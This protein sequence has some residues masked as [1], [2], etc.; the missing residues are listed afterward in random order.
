MAA[1]AEAS[2][3]DRPMPKRKQSS[4][5]LAYLVF[6]G[7]NRLVQGN[8][9]LILAHHIKELNLYNTFS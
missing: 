4:S 1:K 8:I 3:A 2:V 6:K 7:Q 9:I 5:R